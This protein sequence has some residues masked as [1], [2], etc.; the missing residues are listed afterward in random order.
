MLPAALILLVSG[1]AIL[2]VLSTA[3]SA[4]D[5]V[6]IE[7]AVHTARSVVSAQERG[8]GKFAKD[9]TWWD[10]AFQKL[11]MERSPAFADD[12]IGT[13]AHETLEMSTAFVLDGR[14]NTLHAFIEGKAVQADPLRLFVGGLE[15]MIERARA[16]PIDE[17]IAITG[18][19][20]LGDRVHVVGVSVFAPE[21]A[22]NRRPEAGPRS[23]LI[24]S[25]ALD[26][27]LLEW[28]SKDYRLSDLRA[29]PTDAALPETHIA[30]EA[31]D[32]TIVG[33]L[34]WTPDLPGERLLREATMGV[35]AAF[36]AMAA[37][38]WILLRR[39]QRLQIRIEN[40]ARMLHE[41]NAALMERET[42]LREAKETLERASRSK[43]EFLANLS[44][45]LRTPINAIVGFSEIFEAEAYGQIGDARYR[46]YSG[47][48]H[49]SA[50]HMLDLVN[51]TL[52]MSR[53]EVGRLDLVESDVGVGQTIETCV[54]ML[55]RLAEQAGITVTQAVE[56]ALPQLHGDERRIRQMVLNLLSNAI[57]FT[58]SGGRVEV[59]ARR[60]DDGGIVIAVA[61]SGI[62]IAK[63]DVEKALTPFTRLES[64]R[65]HM[66]DGAG[67]GLSLTRF[68]VELHGGRLA[69]ESQVGAGTRVSLYFPATRT[70]AGRSAA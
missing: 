31:P 34:A 2:A 32:G 27:T 10:I 4:I 6:A 54:R 46:E 55:T 44:H 69:I 33:A 61:D 43:S 65:A 19:L 23:L 18:R 7:S 70:A 1:V 11:V 20:R 12:N 9:Y 47:Y 42:A 3:G 17:P 57:K 22:G 21:R 15:G 16:A 48:I 25:R 51:D 14:N 67:I 28:L 66:H 8:V 45:E 38:L 62:G 56:P 50:R 53:A 49:R 29:A 40:D 64:R 36:L 60:M 41:R 63:D 37:L 5:K 68:L 52:D 35:V 59:A 24:F 30:L 39:A 26:D 58:P 13:Y